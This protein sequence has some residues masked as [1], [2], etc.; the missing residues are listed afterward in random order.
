[1]FGREKD[2]KKEVDAAV[3][4]VDFAKNSYQ[5]LLDTSHGPITLD[6]LADVAP[7][8]CRNLI[9]LAKIGFY[10]GLAFHRIIKGFMIQG[11]CPNGSGTGGPGYTIRAEF[12]KTKHLPGVLSM[13]R[14]SDPNSAGSQFFICLE[15]TPHLDGQYTAFGQ[16]ADDASLQVVKTIGSVPTGPNDK[17][18]QPVTIKTATVLVKAK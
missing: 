13:A 5:L 9:G 11:G 12:N 17:P 6:L 14:T 2:R 16:T 10:D 4:E 7:G 3:A 18:K 1:M 8:H 15:A